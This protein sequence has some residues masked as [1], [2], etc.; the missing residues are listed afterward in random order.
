MLNCKD[1]LIRDQLRYEQIR[2]LPKTL[3]YLH[4][5]ADNWALYKNHHCGRLERTL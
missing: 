4:I 1:I 2:F 3:L 5:E